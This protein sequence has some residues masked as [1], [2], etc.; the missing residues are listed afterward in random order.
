MALYYSLTE[1]EN[2]SKNAPAGSK[3]WYAVT[4][5][6]AASTWDDVITQVTAMS[7]ASRG[8]VHLVLEGFL[9]VLQSELAKGRSVKLGGLGSLRPVSGS[10]GSATKEEFDATKNI[11]TP[12]IR[13]IPGKTLTDLCPNIKFERLDAVI[14]AEKETVEEEG[15][16]G[17]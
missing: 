11:K 6:S 16:T 13:F 10:T 1:R 4:R 12:K 17:I 14:A 8:D 15:N 7:T 9:F 2:K 3:L 5:T